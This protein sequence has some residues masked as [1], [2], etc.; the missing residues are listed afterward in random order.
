LREHQPYARWGASGAQM[1]DVNGQLFE[2]APGGANDP[3]IPTLAGPDDQS[4][5]VL[6]MY[7]DLNPLVAPLHDRMA[8]LELE[9]RGDWRA[10]LTGRSSPPGSGT[11]PDAVIELGAGTAAELAARLRTFVAT[12]PMVAARHQRGVADI[13]TADLRHV[14][15]YALRLRG[16]DTTGDPAA[17]NPVTKQ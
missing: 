2:A 16:V 7:R 11:A 1:I 13:E 14:N 4:A 6:A 9:T 15:G 5:T 12:V 3:A 8:V 10:W 17:A